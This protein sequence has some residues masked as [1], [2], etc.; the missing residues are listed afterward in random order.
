MNRST[1]EIDALFALPLTEFIDGR[2]ALAARMKREKRIDEAERVKALAKPPV[3]AWAVNQLYWK[4]REEFERLLAAGKR[5]RDAQ[6]SQLTGKTADVRGTQ[7]ERRDAVSS[8]AR[9]AAAVLRD[10]GHNASPDI[11]R[12]IAT[13]LEAMSAYASLPNAPPPGRLAADVDPP[14]FDALTA[15]IPGGH[16]APKTKVQ[17]PDEDRPAKIAAAKAALREAEG[18]LKQAQADAREAEKTKREAEKRFALA[19]A[20]AEQAA[21]VVENAAR[22]VEKASEELRALSRP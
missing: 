18:V 11:I 8:L 7:D 13:T 4:H 15:L 1:D 5:F 17:K 12:R 10:A 21:T 19:S 2:N 20:D 3:S 16:V 6:T 22:A 14:G 9:L